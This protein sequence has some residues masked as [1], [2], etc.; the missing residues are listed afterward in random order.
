[1]VMRSKISIYL[2]WFQDPEVK[3]LSQEKWSGG[4][5]KGGA[6]FRVELLVHAMDNEVNLI[7]LCVW[8]EYALVEKS[9]SYGWL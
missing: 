5:W 6:S 1:M 2:A 4:G 9:P 8:W 3:I 7:L